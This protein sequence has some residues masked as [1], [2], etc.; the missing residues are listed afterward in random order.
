M[1][2]HMHPHPDERKVLR[3]PGADKGDTNALL[4]EEPSSSKAHVKPSHPCC[5]KQPRKTRQQTHT[6]RT[7]AT[8]VI[9]GQGR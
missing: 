7:S 3:V 9:F 8:E 6:K 2:T 1:G 4:A 5:I